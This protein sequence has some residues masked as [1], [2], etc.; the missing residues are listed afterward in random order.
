V[1]APS[2]SALVNRATDVALLARAHASLRARDASIRAFWFYDLDHVRARAMQL[3]HH[4]NTLRPR[5]HYALK[6]NGLPAL[7]RP[8]R[9]AGLGADAGSLGELELA[10]ACGFPSGA[11]TLSGN[12]RTPEEAAWIARHGVEAVSA[13]LSDELHLLEK[14]VAA[15]HGRLSVSLRVNPGI[16][17]GAH[18]HIE[19]GHAATKFGM[20]RR[21]ALE[22]WRSRAQWPHLDLDGVHVHVGSQVTDATPFVASARLSLELVGECAAFGH[23]IGTVNLGGG[24]AVDYDGSGHELDLAS[25]ASSLAALPGATNVR[26]CFEPGRSLVAAAGTLVAEV[27]WDKRRDDADGERR[28]VVLAAGMNDLLRPALYGARHRIVTLEPRAGEATPADVV[29]P[30]CESSDRFASGVRLPPLATGDLVA[31]LDAGAYGE[32]MSSGYNGRPRLP[33]VVHE[34]GRLMRAHALDA[35]E[36]LEPPSS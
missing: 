23:A 4:L 16:V 9:E 31:L 24:F 6:A 14:E 35:N 36:E 27:L 22:A 2:S 26:W 20:S 10:R 1:S 12:G 18:P 11:R 8:L 25:L 13:D 30:V 21:Q 5:I 28:F 15:A 34:G 3:K 33:E 19:T 17:A 7:L 29:G 32:V